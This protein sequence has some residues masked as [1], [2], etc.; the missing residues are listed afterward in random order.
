MIKGA[1]IDDITDST[2]RDSRSDSACAINDKYLHIAWPIKCSG[3]L[4]ADANSQKSGCEVNQQRLRGLIKTAAKKEVQNKL[5]DV[6]DKELNK[7]LGDGV[8]NEFRDLIKGGLEGL[9]K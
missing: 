9:F 3:V 6:I 7:H 2:R 1:I 4:S 5:K 8:E